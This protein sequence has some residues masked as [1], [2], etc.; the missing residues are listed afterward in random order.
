MS[1]EIQKDERIL[2]GGLGIIDG[3]QI[4]KAESDYQKGTLTLTVAPPP[5]YV[6]LDEVVEGYL[7]SKN[8]TEDADFEVVQPKQIEQ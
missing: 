6:T 7:N 3:G 4:I 5:R 2:P 8:P 1:N